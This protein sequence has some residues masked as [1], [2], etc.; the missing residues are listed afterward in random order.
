MNEKQKELMARLRQVK[1]KLIEKLGYTGGHNL[2]L[3]LVNRFREPNNPLWRVR[4]AAAMC[5]L[6]PGMH[7]VDAKAM[8]SEMSI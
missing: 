8:I 6:C 3:S 1:Q 7:L 2:A 4:A 5:V